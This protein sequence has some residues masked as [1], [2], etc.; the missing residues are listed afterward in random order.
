M[1]V[2]K[3]RW[4]RSVRAMLGCGEKRRRGGGEVRWRMVKP[5]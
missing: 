2:K 5:A 3:W 4:R 1:V